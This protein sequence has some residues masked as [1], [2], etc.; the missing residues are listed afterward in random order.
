MCTCL[1]VYKCTCLQVYKC[2]CLQVYKFTSVHVYKFT[3]VHVYKFT[4]KHLKNLIIDSFSDFYKSSK[5]TIFTF[6]NQNSK[7][8]FKFSKFSKKCKGVTS[9]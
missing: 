2:T 1:Q 5:K 7:T 4:S 8:T 9:W 6:E 3:S